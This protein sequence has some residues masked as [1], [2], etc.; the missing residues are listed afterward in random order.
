MAIGAVGAI[1]RRQVHLGDGLDHEPRQVI[2][3]EPIT[4]VR[5]E[6]KPLLTSA[7][8]EVLS[9]TGMIFGEPDGAN[10]CDSLR[11]ERA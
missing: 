2:V 6:Q 8:N 11:P 5:R 4:H 1:K 10:L 7:L 9:H 3:R